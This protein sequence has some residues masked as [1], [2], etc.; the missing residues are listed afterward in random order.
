MFVYF[1]LFLGAWNGFLTHA[2]I[3]DKVFRPTAS[4]LHNPR[5]YPQR[6]VYGIKSIQ[7]DNW[8]IDEL[9]GNGAG[10]VAV[11]YPW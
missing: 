1:A 6:S 2:L 3:N 10:G 9:V 11:N 4:E 5:V 8:N 7:P